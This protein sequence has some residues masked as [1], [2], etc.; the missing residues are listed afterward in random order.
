MLQTALGTH[1]TIAATIA[2]TIDDTA[3]GTH[4]T[5]AP[6]VVVVVV[7]RQWRWELSGLR[8]R[9]LGLDLGIR[10]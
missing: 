9:A 7:V 2:A 4:A 6:P 10:D 5:T 1:A 3:L 8:V